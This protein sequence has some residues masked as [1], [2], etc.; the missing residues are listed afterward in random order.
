MTIDF[1][2]QSVRA[3]IIDS[4]GN[5]IAMKKEKYE[6]PYF[7]KKPGYAEQEP[8]KY[9]EYLC[10][11]SKALWD[12]N[13]SY[14]DKV[15]GV[16]ITSFRDT[17]VMCDENMKP[18]RPAIIWLDQRR[19]LGK[20]K[21]PTISKVLF[22][23]VGMNNTI[24]LNRERTPAHWVKENEPE[25]WNK[26]KRYMTISTYIT[27]KVIGEYKDSIANYAGHFPTDF[28]NRR[29]Y[30]DGHFQGCIFGIPH[31]MLPT[32]VD[33]GHVM[34]KVTKK[35]SKE[36]GI[37]EGLNCYSIGSDKSCETLGVG[38]MEKG[39]AAISC[40]T[41]SSIEITSKKFCHPSKF[42]P[43]YPSVIDG[44]Y[45]CE[46]QVYRGYW[47]LGWFASQFAQ[48]EKNEAE[49]TGICIEELLNRKLKEV[50]PGS[51][52]LVLQPYW[53]PGLSRPLSRGAVIGFSDT[54]TKSHL[55]RS[56]IEGIDYELKEGLIGMEKSSRV[57]TK[58]LRISGGGSQQDEI[59]QIAADIFDLP[60]SRVQTFETTSLGA[61]M[62]GFIGAGVFS[63]YK[64]ATDSMIH[65]SKTFEP[66]K[67]NAKK[68]KYLFEHCYCKMYPALKNIYKD[69][70][71]NEDDLNEEVN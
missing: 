19:A 34:G 56:I 53:G 7:S 17:A 35:C 2:T 28:K 68:Y 8:E 43:S 15:I 39:V 67:K 40:G 71:L 37:P 59:C 42:L 14:K 29:F 58:E 52:G 23:L 6:P 12:E 24:K 22:K 27:Y 61:A 21:L 25:I 64:E 33:V 3:G 1:G 48:R 70:K 62:A 16:A 66:N 4:T 26:V 41:A 60:T 54:H 63:N 10:K 47:M 5:I 20:E 32:I 50:P 45:N 9:Y 31:S 13:K 18:L 51:N 11:A 57:K 46:V 30:P 36:T 65:V 38:A 69:I 44:Y 55:Y 49:K